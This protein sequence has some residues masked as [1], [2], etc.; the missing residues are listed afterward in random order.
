MPAG[1]QSFFWGFAAPRRPPEPSSSIGSQVVRA[2]CDFARPTSGLLPSR[3]PAGFERRPRY[4][5]FAMQ[6]IITWALYSLA[7][8]LAAALLG[9]FKIRGGLPGVL[10]VAALFG[11][12]NWALAWL[13]KIVLGVLSLGLLWVLG[14]VLHA[15]V[16][17]IVLKITDAFSDKLEIK[18]FW[19]ALVAGV[20]MSLTVSVARSVVLPLLGLD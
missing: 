1:F 4:A 16:T 8:A 5:V 2:G 18:S 19:T 13:L 10:G 7:L 14:F 11:I 20:I 6:M 12:L 3:M 9:G 15:L 17:A